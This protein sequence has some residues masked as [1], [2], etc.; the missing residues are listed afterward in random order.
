MASTPV[1]VRPHAETPCQGNV[2][3]KAGPRTPTRLPDETRTYRPRAQQTHE[4]TETR[5]RRRGFGP[6]CCSSVHGGSVLLVVRLGLGGTFPEKSLSMVKENGYRE[7]LAVSELAGT[8][9]SGTLRR[10]QLGSP[11]ISGTVG[12]RSRAHPSTS[13]RSAL[14]APWLRRVTRPCAARSSRAR[15][16]VVVG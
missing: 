3:E 5:T 7:C 1:Q 12:Q 4:P 2:R 15:R 14:P 13:H 8:D 11:D 9:I 16:V 6:L 10:V